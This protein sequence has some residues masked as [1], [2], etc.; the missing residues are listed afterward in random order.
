M[1]LAAQ[2]KG[3]KK[4]GRID[5][6]VTRALPLVDPSTDQLAPMMARF[7]PKGA[8]D[9]P[10][11]SPPGVLP[12]TPVYPMDQAAPVPPTKPPVPAEAPPQQMMP[13]PQQA[14][15]MPQAKPPVP[16]S[17]NWQQ[18][19]PWAG[20]TF[21]GMAKGGTAKKFA[22]GG[23]PTSSDLAPWYTRDEERG[24]VHP[25][26]LIAG[27]GGGRTDVHPIQVP[28]GSYILPADVVSGLSEGNSQAGSAVIDKM[29]RS[30]PYGIEMGGGRHGSGPPRAPSVRPPGPMAQGGSADK[31]TGKLVPIIA[32]AGEHVIW[33]QQIIRKFGSLDKGHRIL[34]KFVLAVRKKTI[35]DMKKLKGPK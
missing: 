33:P 15:P 31:H 13:P 5:I 14:A 7:I 28:S 8:N 27:I 9:Y 34:D 3:F 6:T 18:Q 4:G 11:F 21:N 35:D 30:A 2:T 24:I 1:G 19:N 20:E 29:M 10:S 26:G 17:G 32:A 22:P 25:P 16:Q 23:I 12:Y